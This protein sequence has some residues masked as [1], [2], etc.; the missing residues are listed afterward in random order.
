[1]NDLSKVSTSDLQVYATRMYSY[2]SELRDHYQKIEQVEQT[3]KI[4]NYDFLSLKSNMVAEI[5]KVSKIN[6]SLQDELQKSFTKDVGVELNDDKIFLEISG[7]YELLNV[8][9][10]Q[11]MFSAK[12]SQTP[13]A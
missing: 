4:Q 5:T 11:E 2:I 7:F 1:M 8:I 3:N 9:H 10:Q 12:Q 6:E 13:N